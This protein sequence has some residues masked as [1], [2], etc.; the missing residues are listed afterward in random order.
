MTQSKYYIVHR[1]GIPPLETRAFQFNSSVNGFYDLYCKKNL[2]IFIRF[3]EW[4]HEAIDRG[5]SRSAL[6][7]TT[8]PNHERGDTRYLLIG[9]SEHDPMRLLSIPH[10]GRPPMVKKFLLTF[11]EAKAMLNSKWEEGDRAM[12]KPS[13]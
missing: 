1:L 7:I 8:V 2:S 9:D 6:G 4:I 3:R 11:A 10:D 5:S 13:W 12:A